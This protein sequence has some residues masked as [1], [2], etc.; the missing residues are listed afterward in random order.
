MSSNILSLSIFFLLCVLIKGIP[1]SVLSSSCPI[2]FSLHG[3]FC[4]KVFSLRKLDHRNAYEACESTGSILIEPTSA[5]Q[6]Q[7]IQNLFR[8]AHSFWIGLSSED[9][10]FEWPD[11]AEVRYANWAMGFPRP[12]HDCVIASHRHRYQWINV[13]CGSRHLFA[14]QHNSSAEPESGLQFR[15]RNDQ[16]FSCRN[17]FGYFANPNDCT[18]YILC[19]SNENFQYS[20]AEGSVFVASRSRCEVGATCETRPTQPLTTVAP[21]SESTPE[22]EEN[23]P[24]SVAVTCPEGYIRHRRKCYKTFKSYLTWKA[25]NESCAGTEGGR[26]VVITDRGVAD[27]VHSLVNSDSC[28]GACRSSHFSDYWIGL[29]DFEEPEQFV[30]SDGTALVNVN[31][32]NWS[33]RARKR[34]K[35]LK[36]CVKMSRFYDFQWI[37]SMCNN[38]NAYI[39]EKE[40]TVQNEMLL[41][42]LSD[43]ESLAQSRN[44]PT[45]GLHRL[46]GQPLLEGVVG[47]TRAQPSLHPWQ[48]SLRTRGVHKCGASL[49]NRCWAMTAAHCVALP[50]VLPRDVPTVAVLGDYEMNVVEDT[51][52]RLNIL[53]IHT[54]PDWSA[55]PVPTNDISLIRLRNCSVQGIPVCLPTQNISDAFPPGTRCIV[56]G[57]G[58]TK[59]NR[60]V[61]PDTLQQ[62]TV[63]LISQAQCT[64]MY[65]QS[66][67]ERHM[68]SS[69][70]CAGYK[71]G[72]IDSCQ[73]D[74]GGPLVCTDPT[75]DSRI[76]VGIVSWGN[77]CARRNRPGVYTSTYHYTDWIE[78]VISTVVN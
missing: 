8:T 36:Q 61:Y 62:A 31:Y 7:H 50:N 63:P 73:G 28:Q 57:Y 13:D 19:V 45:C 9:G 34:Y 43:Q 42:T 3:D 76:Q 35:D 40:G 15:N 11:G 52:E 70:L 46:V 75:T 14:C 68:R 1:S 4:Y 59:P 53:D 17:K 71:E 10:T 67:Q 48:V 30:W 66:V 54:H 58:T 32:E 77:G 21:A 33:K 37:D 23:Q 49:I 72:G 2:G 5:E 25:A 27:F 74:S 18:S 26:M 55:F 38:A 39:C 65:R 47:G 51:E 20:C 78:S 16:P 22:E 24:D 64:R 60:E 6:Q 69:M 41:S 12:N 56:S 44:G 29:N